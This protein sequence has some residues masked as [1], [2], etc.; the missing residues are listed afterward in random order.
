[1]LVIPTVLSHFTMYENQAIV[2][3]TLNLHSDIC[4]FFLN[5]AGKSIKRTK[6]KALPGQ[7]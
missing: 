1:M 3:Y 6:A 5:K 7:C 2:L 4:Q